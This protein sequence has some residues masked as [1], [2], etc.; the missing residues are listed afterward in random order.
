M[1]Y[2]VL[3]LSNLDFVNMERYTYTNNDVILH[4]HAESE[5]KVN[6]KFLYCF[7]FMII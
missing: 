5:R 7:I 4:V 2:Y 1:Y 3:R 6:C